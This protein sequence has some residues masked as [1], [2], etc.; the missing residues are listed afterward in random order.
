MGGIMGIALN[1]MSVVPGTML[2]PHRLTVTAAPPELGLGRLE[3]GAPFHSA[4]PLQQ[5]HLFNELRQSPE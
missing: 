4:L 1:T 3:Q 5:E 2:L